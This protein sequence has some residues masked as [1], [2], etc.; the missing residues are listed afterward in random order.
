MC[1][2]IVN[3]CFSKADDSQQILV[4]ESVDF[5]FEFIIDNPTY[6][7][8]ENTKSQTFILLNKLISKFDE[9]KISTNKRLV[10]FIIET[11][12]AKTIQSIELKKNIV[13]FLLNNLRGNEVGVKL[14]EKDGD[15]VHTITD[16]MREGDDVLM[17]KC[18][19]LLILH[20][21][22]PEANLV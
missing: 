19:S 4:L 6:I 20:F 14:F 18:K 5:L 9:L 21:S 15:V 8:S 1:V 13:H 2:G 12:N 16:M 11:F 10:P 3:I 17:L 22:I 7:I